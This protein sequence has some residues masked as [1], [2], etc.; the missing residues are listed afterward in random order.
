LPAPDEEVQDVRD[1]F[2]TERVNASN[3][4]HWFA[5]W[6]ALSCTG[7]PTMFWVQAPQAW[8]GWIHGAYGEP[9][10][11]SSQAPRA[12][13]CSHLIY[14]QYSNYSGFQMSKDIGAYLDGYKRFNNVFRLNRRGLCSVLY[15]KL[16]PYRMHRRV[17][18][19]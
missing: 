7:L 6:D 3:C 19:A 5:D 10:R 15:I 16:E 12:P 11:T 4:Q 13:A 2:D 1:K 14:K 18:M 9:T 17:Y 8:L